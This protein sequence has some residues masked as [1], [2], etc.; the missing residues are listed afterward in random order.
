MFY[1]LWHGRHGEQ[2]PFDITRILAQNP[3]A[4]Q[5]PNHPLWGP[6]H[7]PHH[8]GE[9]IFGYYVADDDFVL[10]KHAQMLSD[11]GV[12]VVIFDVTNQLTYPESW[13]ALVR[14]FGEIRRQ[15]GR[16]PQI[17]FLAP[18][19]DPRKVVR[20]LY[21]QLYRPR[22]HPELW[23]QWKDHPLILADPALL[24]T[25]VTSGKRE[26]PDRLL[27]GHTLGQWIESTGTVQSVAICLPTWKS[28]TSSVTL[29]L[30]SADPS[31]RVVQSQRLMN[32]Q[33]NAWSVLTLSNAL[34]TG[35]YFVEISEPEGSVGW[36]RQSSSTK[37]DPV[38]SFAREAV[39][40][41]QQV[42]G[43]RMCRLEFIDPEVS[44]IRSF[45]TFRKP[46]PDYFSG[47]TGPD[48][49]GWLEVS[50]QHGFTNSLG[51]LEE[52]TVGVAQNAVD[53]KLSVLSN[54]RSH[55]R[56]FHEG[57]QPDAAGTDSTGR[58]VQE[59]WSRALRMDPP[60]VFVTGWNEW[61]AGRFQHP[62]GFYGDGPV[63]FVD[64]FNQE[65]SRDIEPM[66]GGHGDL[67]YYQFAGF[68]RRFKGVRPLTPVQSH[69][70]QIDGSFEDWSA[71]TPE[72]RDTLNDAVQRQYR[73]WGKGSHYEN[74]SGRNDFETAKISL[75]SGFLSC[76]V[77][78]LNPMT[79]ADA[80]HWMLLFL[81]TDGNPTN[82]WMG[83]DYVV[84]HHR[85]VLE[86]HLGPGYQ[87]GEPVPISMHTRQEGRE[88]ELQIPRSALVLKKELPLQIDFK[89]ADNI[90]ENGDWSDFT[91]HGDVAPNDRFNFR[92]LFLEE[93]KEPIRR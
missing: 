81:N 71:V 15:R 84:N 70:I 26:V 64:Q 66:H 82:G 30:R 91:L 21:Q 79:G 62:S 68:V 87:W 42:P 65:Y 38:S 24:G 13:E 67:F 59:Q 4:L 78:T 46:Q 50:P 54:P 60:V 69:P 88:L 23:F 44:E 14:V 28:G 22:V 27:P 40:D 51:Q 36:W 49:W 75:S 9:S 12:D 56:S 61:I 52:M 29:T 18:F 17:A 77:R 31:P 85:G 11:A 53:G 3:E 83:Y 34:P 55:G 39:A 20:E 33:D 73:G 35:R 16:T 8:W 6:M 43:E 63:T 72:F 10:R 92:G 86:R 76:Y 37:V 89:W 7:V 25:S 93:S 74:H 45:F 32:L 58:N 19:W 1:F 80:D 2:G 41:G 57:K 90:E 5:Q 48:Q 47:P